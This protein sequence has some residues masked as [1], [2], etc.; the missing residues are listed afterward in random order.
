[1]KTCNKLI[2]F[3]FSNLFTTSKEQL[4]VKLIYNDFKAN[5]STTKQT[6]TVIAAEYSQK[7]SKQSA[8]AYLITEKLN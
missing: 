5:Y 3:S 8:G 2:F 1:M 6:C 4:S 7:N